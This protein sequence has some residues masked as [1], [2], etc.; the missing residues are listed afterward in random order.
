MAIGQ[1]Q[2]PGFRDGQFSSVARVAYRPHRE[3]GKDTHPYLRKAE[4]QVLNGQAV[5]RGLLDLRKKG[6]APDLVF[7]HI[8][9]GEALYVKD[10]FPDAPLI[11]YCEFYYHAR[12]VDVGFDP[13]YPSS[14][15]D[16]FRVR[17]L[18]AT[19]LL[20]LSS[21]DAGVSPTRWQKSLF[22]DAFQEKIRV[23][24]EGLDTQRVKPDGKA[25]LTLPDG[26]TLTKDTEVVTYTA[27]GLEP[28]R[29]FHIFM[30][31]AE[32]ICRRRPNC[33]IVITGGDAVCYGQKLPRG[34]SHR[35]RLLKEVEIDHRRVHFMGIVPYDIHLKALQISS[36]HV[37]LTVPFVLSWSMLEAMATESVVIGSATPPVEEVIKDGE[38]G[39]LV[40]FFSP[41]GIAERVD[42]VLDHP[43]RMRQIGA[44][45]RTDVAEQYDV[46]KSL[47][48]YDD[49]WRSLFR[50]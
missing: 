47:T 45:A 25:S 41:Q 21:I 5:A 3:P 23:I 30:R 20:T 10:I 33:H 27:R 1:A 46:K 35:E 19:Q 28:Y 16:L 50:A 38:N 44:R 26:T 12:G 4:S 7:A 29:G 13:E 32:E 40:D 49:L 48:V 15:D 11:G 14:M 34:Q 6:F 8:G 9:W 31:A 17:T 2:A 24:H 22:P 18:N 43:R 42:E 39:L 36:C 37:Y